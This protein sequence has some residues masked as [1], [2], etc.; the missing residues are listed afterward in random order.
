[1]KF[2]TGRVPTT[3]MATAAAVVVTSMVFAAWTSNGTGSATTKAGSS[4]A[5]STVDASAS[6]SA[7]L[8]PGVDGDVKLT[9]SNPNPFAVRVTNVSLNGTNSDITP[10]GSHSGCDPTGVS[11]TNQTGLSIDVPG[12]SGG[13]NGSATAT[14]TGA[15]SMSNASV[16]A[17]QGATF[18]IPVSLTGSSNAS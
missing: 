11:F 18:T 14:L 9:I 15:A 5:L 10:D 1:M 6:T 3:L 8:Y 12:K 17:C 2:I 4:S 7:T 13:T 16:N